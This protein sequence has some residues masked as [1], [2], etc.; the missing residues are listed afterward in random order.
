MSR[1]AQDYIKQHLGA[2]HPQTLIILGS[3]LGRLGEQIE[4]P[5]FIDYKDIPSW[6]QSTVAGHQGR[7][8]AGQIEGKEVLC[9]QG[10]F[11]LYE[12]H[13]PQVIKD[14][15]TTFKALGIK[16]LIV[17][18]AAGSLKKDMAPGSIMLIT[19]HINFSGKNPLIGVNDD[20]QGPRFPVM[21]EAYTPAFQEKIKKIAKEENITLKEGVYL[22]VLGP[23]FETAA[24]IR[25]FQILGADAVGMST[26]PEVLS[27]VYCG[28]NILGLS[29]I[30]NFGTGLASD[31][32]GHEETLA[33]ADKAAQ[34][35]TKLVRRFVKEI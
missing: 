18:N 35:L 11:H 9:M 27:A 8:I 21:S 15:M 5:V 3:G 33:Q 12:G 16:N 29:V 34:N 31:F 10:R 22:M 28:F 14:V 17:T 7:L 26:V 32:H 24:E 13:A 2:Y 4:A 23:N 19:D 30:T 1:T 25:A 6:P 20:S